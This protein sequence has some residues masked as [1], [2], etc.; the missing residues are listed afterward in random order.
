LKTFV[1][2]FLAIAI[3][4]GLIAT[5]LAASAVGTRTL[6]ADNK[7][8]GFD[9]AGTGTFGN[10]SQLN[11]LTGG[12]TSVGTRGTFSPNGFPLQASFDVTEN[13]IYWINSDFQNAIPNYLMKANITTGASVIVG[14]LKD[15]ATAT[16]ID[17]L[18]IAPTGAAY[19]FSE[20]KFYSINKTTGALTQINGSTGQ[21]R[22][23]SFSYNPADQNFWAV[24]NDTDGGLYTVNVA[25]GAVTLQLSIASFP[26]L[27]AGTSV[28]AKRVYSM[29]IDQ[30][31]SFWGV[32]VDGD[33]FSSVVTGT[34]SADF[35]TGIQTVGTPGQT[36]TNS[37]AIT[38]P[39]PAENNANNPGEELANTG[40]N[41]DLTIGLS[42]AALVALTS[43]ASM[44][45]FARRRSN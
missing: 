3:A 24:S 10:L 2:P 5:P 21:T 6:A 4:V 22:F 1:K 28:G 25:T 19:G 7:L 35:V 33:L 11:E 18:A 20:D 45:Y 30:N 34:N 37:I 39:A 27:G 14:E 12:N 17:A 44:L 15:G 31:G 16:P 13:A 42:T 32:N 29:A 8:F 43:G 23:Y 38:Y 36:A 41:S 9:G 40:T 26:N